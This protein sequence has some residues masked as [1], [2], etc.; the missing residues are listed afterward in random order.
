LK[1]GNLIGK[2]AILILL[3]I[4]A[5]ISVVPVR[6]EEEYGLIATLQS[7]TPDSNGGFG[8]EIALSEGLFLIGEKYAS[9]DDLGGG[10]KAYIFDSYG[11][12]VSALS[13][14]TPK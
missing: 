2:Y 6:A 7:P 3:C 13:P 1:L 12:L 4:L 10:G 5:V 11:V 8:S 14:P 9:V